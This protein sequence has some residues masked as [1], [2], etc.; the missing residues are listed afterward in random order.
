M[1]RRTEAEKVGA[2]RNPVLSSSVDVAAVVEAVGRVKEYM[3]QAVK[4]TNRVWHADLRALILF[5]SRRLADDELPVWTLKQ[6]VA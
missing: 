5:R 2:L 6:I 3:A 1:G 4:A